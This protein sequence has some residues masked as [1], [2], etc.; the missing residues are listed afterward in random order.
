[1]RP[2][3]RF[4]QSPDGLMNPRDIEARRQLDEV[5]FLK[6]LNLTEAEMQDA[7]FL[8]EA[9][10]AVDA[11]HTLS[12]DRIT[13][14]DARRQLIDLR[15]RVLRPQFLDVDPTRGLLR[16]TML[17]AFLRYRPVSMEDWPHVPSYLRDAVDERQLRFLPRVFEIVS[18]IV[19]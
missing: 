2:L 14:D 5:I 15:E 7:V 13:A 6:A 10:P 8:P 12:S 18:R 4:Q 1:M 9:R 19:D 11:T 16:K 3:L 17:D